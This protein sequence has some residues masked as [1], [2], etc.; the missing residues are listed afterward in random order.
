MRSFRHFP[1]RDCGFT[2]VELLVILAIAAISLALA[3][4][5]IQAAS[6]ASRQEICQNNL[7]QLG[8][9]LQS[10][11]ETH[12]RFPYTTTCSTYGPTVPNSGH[13]W[14]EFLLPYMDMSAVYLK[15]DFNIPN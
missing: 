6:E 13:T 12:D 4:P 2:T 1:R 15:L 5:A 9:A 3:L 11:H 10:Y 8:V 7:K 14:N